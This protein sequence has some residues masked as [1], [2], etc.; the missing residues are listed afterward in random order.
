MYSSIYQS[1]YWEPSAALVAFFHEIDYK[2]IVNNTMTKKNT[3]SQ[4][5]VNNT[6]NTSKSLNQNINDTLVINKI[7]SYVNTDRWNKIIRYVR[8]GKFVNLN[9]EIEND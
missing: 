9:L 4:E 1:V 3:D 7:R 5:Q 8:E 2:I 6:D